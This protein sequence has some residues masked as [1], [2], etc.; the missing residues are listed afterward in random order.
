MGAGQT[1]GPAAAEFGPKLSPATAQSDIAGLTR[2][3]TFLTESA[4]QVD[5]L[6]GIDRALLER[7]LAWLVTQP[8]GHSTKEDAVTAPGAFFQAIR[9]HGWDDS[10]PTTAVFFPGDMPPRPPRVT[11]HVAEHV[12]AQVE[13]P[14][15]LD[16]WPTPEG[17]LITII[18][19]RCGL[20]ATDAC[21]LPFDCLLH[22]GQQVA[23][24]RYF[25]NKMRREAAVP[26]DEELERQIR[27]QQQRVA[28]RWPAHHPHL[29]PA[30]DRQRRRSQPDDLLQLPRHAHHLAGGLRSPRR[31]RPPR[32]P[33]PAPVEAH[34]R[35]SAD[36]PRRPP[37]SRPSPARPPIT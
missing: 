12:M 3:S 6:A 27:A 15:N 36:Q 25:N 28:A 35:L 23:Y 19:I 8:L 14:A 7:Y 32:A 4:A 26:I 17:R 24:L 22:D 37:R 31:T 21:T 1:L 33:N 34:L 13:A 2:F 18:L 30:G 20:R 5:A 16:R 11:R 10:L 9:Q 29:F